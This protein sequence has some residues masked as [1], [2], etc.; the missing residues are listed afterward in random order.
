MTNHATLVRVGALT[1]YVDLAR[2]LRLEPS[3]LLQ[4]CGLKERNLSDCDGLIPAANVAELLEQSAEAAGVEDFG[5]RLAQMRKLAEIGPVGLVVR[6]EPT[7]RHGIRA[8]EQFF[9]YY[10]NSVSFRL[11]EHENTAVLRIRFLPITEGRIRQLTELMIGTVFRIARALAG[12]DW[13]PEGVA[14]SHPAPRRRTIHESFF[15]TRT[16]FDNNFNGFIFRASDLDAPVQMADIAMPRYIKHYI[17]EVV[18]QPS[19]KI[20]ATVRQ[21]LF[22]FLPSG[23]CSSERVANHIG[24][25][26]KTIGRWLAAEGKT[27]SSLL[28]E[29]RIELARRHIRTG[30]KSLTETAQLLGFSGLATFS[31][32]FRTEFGTSATRYQQQ[33]TRNDRIRIPES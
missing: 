16:L 12:G 8:A 1:S 22:A 10:S 19:I 5:L 26:R 17:E 14:L 7:I 13:T 24:V 3:A 32:W 23:H 18:A 4:S 27:F 11:D 28:N 6:E 15:G 25:D 30:H 9:Q 31:R 29:V 20:D 33:L 2:S 21:L